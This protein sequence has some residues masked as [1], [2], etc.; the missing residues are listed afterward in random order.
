MSRDTKK[1]EKDPTQLFII[2]A[3]IAQSVQRWATG[4]T[5]GVLGFDFRRGLRN[6]LFTTVP[7][8]PLGPTQPPIQWIPGA[9]SLVVKRPGRD[10]DHSLP[11]SAEVKECV[12]LYLHPP[13]RLH[14]VVIIKKKHRDNF[15]V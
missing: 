2:R 4:W 9:V 10:A 15:K 12:E 13:V 6:F 3:V 8:T 11:S 14:G 7:R 5:I 1:Y